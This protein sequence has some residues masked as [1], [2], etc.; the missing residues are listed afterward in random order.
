MRKTYKFYVGGMHCKACVVLTENALSEV[1]RV[2]KVKSS[3][4]ARS[5]EINGDFGDKSEAV[6]VENFNEVLRPHGYTLSCVVQKHKV[7]WSD[8]YMAIPVASAFIALFIVLQKLGIINL[9]NISEMSYGAIFMLG[10]VASL[11]ACMAIC[12]G[13]LLSMSATLPADY[14]RNRAHILFHI[15]R[16]IAFFL[17]GG[18]IGELGSMFQFSFMGVFILN[19]LV[20]LV[21]IV[22]GINLLD[23]L[24][25]ISKL[26]ITIPNFI[27]LYIHKLKNINNAFMPFLLG[28]ATFFLPCGF[29]QSAQMYALTTGSFFS[30]ALIMGLFVIGTLPA[31]ALVSLGSLK[32]YQKIQSGIFFKTVGLIVLFF[33]FFTLLGALISIGLIPP[34][35]NF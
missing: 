6:I 14:N 32:V 21:F 25:R 5:V 18:L 23:I 13:L 26:Q 11:S 28:V 31:L 19:S 17:L 7:Q 27:G 16:I 24:P 3:L 8:F 29:T 35:F 33:G 15:G 20:A 34:L 22:L 2:Y 9:L 12:G 4:S 1:P 30:G 10:L